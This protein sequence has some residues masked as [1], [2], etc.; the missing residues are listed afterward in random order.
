MQFQATKCIHLNQNQTEWI[1][2][3]IHKRSVHFSFE[4]HKDRDGFNSTL[5][6]DHHSFIHSFIILVHICIVYKL[7]TNYKQYRFLNIKICSVVISIWMD[8]GL[9]FLYAGMY[10]ILFLSFSESVH[11]K[12]FMDSFDMF[13]MMMEKTISISTLWRKENKIK[14]YRI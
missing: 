12:S 6:H 1:W 8:V 10:Y 13:K 14:F 11:F 4:P 2:T 3:K 9:K 5:I 7:C